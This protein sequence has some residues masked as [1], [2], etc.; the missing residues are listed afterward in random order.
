MKNETTRTKTLSGFSYRAIALVL[1]FVM[2]L[3]AIGSGSVLSA[4]A[5][6]FE[7]NGAAV[8]V[9]AAKAG[10]S[11]DVA[12]DVAAADDKAAADEDEAPL[13]KKAD[14]DLADTGRDADVA[15]TGWGV[16]GG[17]RVYFVNT[18]NWN[19]VYHHFWGSD[20]NTYEQMTQ[21]SGTGVYS[22]WYDNDY[23]SDGFNFTN[24]QSTTGG[25]KA[26]NDWVTGDFVYS[27]D[28]TMNKVTDHTKMNGTAKVKTRIDTGDGSYDLEANA[29]CVATISS[30]NIPTGWSDTQATSDSTGSSSSA[31]CYPAY[32]ASVKY[33]ASDGSE[34][35]FMGFSTTGLTS[36][37]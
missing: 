4:I 7:G 32:G 14:S 36:L 34:Y 22:K 28:N 30:I 24:T 11:V 1:C 23:T 35:E 26:R 2:L 3:T 31:E 12:A 17:H 18:E 25:T 13:T 21:I 8:L 9:D 37:P 6:D 29:D 33:S 5:A 15:A 19:T 20:W 10:A 27:G 16:E